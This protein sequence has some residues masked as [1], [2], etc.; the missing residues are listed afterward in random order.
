[1]VARLGVNLS[2]LFSDS[3]HRHL[4]KHGEGLKTSSRSKRACL[5]C[6]A[7]KTKCDGEDRCQPCLKKGIECQYRVPDEP[8]PENG[9]GNTHVVDDSKLKNL[10]LNADGGVGGDISSPPVKPLLAAGDGRRIAISPSPHIDWTDVRLQMDVIPKPNLARNPAYMDTYFTHFHHRF[11][12]I[13]RPSYEDHGKASVQPLL[14]SSIDMIGA[15]LYGTVES[16][17]FAVVVH[18]K[19]VSQCLVEIVSVISLHGLYMS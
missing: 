10:T 19:M 13:H 5:A 7:A 15:W 18:H 12:V 2:F 8:S 14:L 4:N 1:M 9:Q 16:K 6:H 3:L 17:D 11:P